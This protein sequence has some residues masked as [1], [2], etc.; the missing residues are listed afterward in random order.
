MCRIINFQFQ[1]Y[2]KLNIEKIA[3]YNIIG[4]VHFIIYNKLNFHKVRCIPSLPAIIKKPNSQERYASIYCS[5][6]IYE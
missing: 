3:N 6:E 2:F 5:Y 1:F 4:I